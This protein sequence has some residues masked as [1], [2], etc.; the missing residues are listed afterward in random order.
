MR[1]IDSQV[2]RGSL[3]AVVLGFFAL[4][5]CK[6]AS[7]EHKTD[8]PPV[9]EVQGASDDFSGLSG[10]YP[11]PNPVVLAQ[12]LNKAG[13]SYILDI[14][15]PAASASN[16]VSESAQALNL[17]VYGAD[18]SYSAIYKKSQE[19]LD[20]YNASKTLSDQLGVSSSVYQQS[21]AKR[22]EDNI[23]SV[24]SLYAI[25]SGSFQKTYSEMVQNGQG[26]TALM[27]LVGGVVEGLYLSVELSSISPNN[28]EIVK[29]VGSQLKTIQS[30]L[31]VLDRLSVNDE[32]LL[33]LKDELKSISE[34][35]SPS[36]DDANSD[37]SLTS[38]ELSEL[39]K[40]VGSL[41]SSFVKAS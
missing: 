2:I 41:R 21:L 23:E 19:T 15:N 28:V 6:D 10:E 30:L 1:L 7:V 39:S 24:D 37:F 40:K 38:E 36:S 12:T 35:L 5:G 8:E 14:T 26:K 11:I 22:M 34:T 33:T 27:V 29:V 9:E 18:L 25:L 4:A 3:S 13:A 31:A 20:F 16:Y 32:H 17:G